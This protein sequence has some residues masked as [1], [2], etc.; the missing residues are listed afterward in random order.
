MVAIDA[1][2]A[3]RGLDVGGDRFKV[4][5]LAVHSAQEVGIFVEGREIVIAGNHVGT[6]VAGTAVLANGVYGVEVYGGDNLIGGPRHAD[7]NV[8]AGTGSSS[9]AV[10]VEGGSGHEIEGN[11]IGTTADGT[12]SIGGGLCGVL[13]ESSG[14]F[15]RDN[16]ISGQGHGVGVWGDDNTLQGNMIGTDV[17]GTGAI[18]NGSAV[19]IE[20]GDHNLLGGSG[21]GEGNLIS[22]NGFHALR[23]EPGDPSW[24]EQEPGPAVG[25][26]VEGNLVGTDRFGIGALPNGDPGGPLTL[27]AIS[28][29]D[30]GG[31]TIGGTQPGAGNVIATNAGDGVEVVGDAAVENPIVGNAIFANGDAA[32]ELGIDLESD[33]VTLN[34]P[35]DADAGANGLQNHPSIV[36]A[37]NVAAGTKV[38]WTLDGLPSTE[39]RLEFFANDACDDSGHGEGQVYLGSTDVVTDAA[40]HAA[41]NTVPA[42]AAAP[43][44]QVAM[45]ATRS[46]LGAGDTSEFSPCQAVGV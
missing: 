5:G 35:L 28:I 31:N 3:F 10:Q 22:G 9:C 20:G 42:I 16:L 29:Q 41:G 34:D 40:G 1:T 6:D 30:T 7:R 14:N 38:E 24:P 25:N 18:A 15:L 26:R 43:G 8:L 32:G 12:A 17:T 13:I 11:R 23:I 4:R 21:A 33:G 19:E 27:A 2:N 45:T 39:F 36:V 37:T 46:A 44:Q